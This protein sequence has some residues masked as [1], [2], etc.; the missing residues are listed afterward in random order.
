MKWHECKKKITKGL[1][2]EE[3]IDKILTEKGQ[4]EE[5]NPLQMK[6]SEPLIE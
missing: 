6:A 1:V 4:V 2:W 5:K 3:Q